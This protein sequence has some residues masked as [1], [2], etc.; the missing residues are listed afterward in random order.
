MDSKKDTKKK[1]SSARHEEK[2]KI[3]ILGFA[4]GKDRLTF[5]VQFSD[6]TKFYTVYAESLLSKY[7]TEVINFLE[8]HISFS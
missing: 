5:I 3:N 2:K 8:S 7:Q 4:D 6:D 1:K